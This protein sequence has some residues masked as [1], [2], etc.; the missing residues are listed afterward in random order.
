MRKIFS[1]V[2]PSDDSYSNES[3][4]ALQA[5]RT[6]IR[7]MDVYN[8]DRAAK[9]LHMHRAELINGEGRYQNSIVCTEGPCVEGF[10]QLGIDVD[11]IPIARELS[12]KKMMARI[13]PIKQIIIRR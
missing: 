5:N 9:E 2:E 11:T 6:P 13:D 8:V 10:L 1:L 12:Q 3:R 7:V 4:I